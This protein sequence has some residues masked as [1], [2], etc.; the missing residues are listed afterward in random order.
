MLL[1]KQRRTAQRRRPPGHQLALQLCQGEGH[2]L[3]GQAHKRQA[4]AH[5]W[6]EHVPVQRGHVLLGGGQQAQLLQEGE[7]VLVACSEGGGHHT[8]RQA[9]RHSQ[10][11][12][13]GE[14]LL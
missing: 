11:R 6:V 3:P 8:T 2:H 13:G 5:G 12:R 7:G 1:Q 14:G 10:L 9:T 4:G